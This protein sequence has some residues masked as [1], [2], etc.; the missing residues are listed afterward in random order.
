MAEGPATAST[1]R[2]GAT[3][4]SGGIVA[5]PTLFVSEGQVLA[6]R[7]LAAQAGQVDL[8]IAG[9]R[10]SARSNLPLAAGEALR[11]V[12]AEATSQRIV[13]REAPGPATG[14]AQPTALT[15]AGLSTAAARALLA[16]V[17]EVN[18]AP[19]SPGEAAALGARAV[20]AGVGTPAEAAAF[21]RLSAADLPTTRATVAGMAQLSEGPPLGRALALVTTLAAQIL[22]EGRAAAPTGTPPAAGAP[23]TPSASAPGPGA[24]PNAPAPAAPP[25]PTTTGPLPQSA[26][27]ASP[28]PASAATGGAA[29]AA[30][31]PPTDA[32]RSAAPVPPAPAAGASASSAAPPPASPDTALADLVRGLRSAV[33]SVARAAVT[34][35]AASVERAVRELGP[36]LARQATPQDPPSVRALLMAI[37]AHPAADPAL[38]R[39]ATVAADAIGAQALAAPAQPAASSDAGAYL[40]LPLPD[41][42]TAEVRVL[43]DRE[44]DGGGA[45]GERPRRVAFLLHLSALGTVMIDAASSDEGVDAVVRIGDPAAQRFAAG[46]AAELERDLRRAGASRARV[47]IEPLSNEADARPLPPPPASGLDLSA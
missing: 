41:G 29:V 18:T 44:D 28:A 19:R 31:P 13:L 20:A 14:T 36:A 16:S 9:G 12:V 7:V 11:L 10:I 46:H 6:A 27:P 33:D 25:T 22:N 39:A 38:A 24:T 47:A 45:E 15:N 2:A 37:A 5:A 32:A 17:A 30:T 35:E 21:A 1:S 8:S 34:G 3:V 43:P 26:T 23:T 40:Q 42:G 4:P